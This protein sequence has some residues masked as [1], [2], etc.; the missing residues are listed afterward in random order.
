MPDGFEQ[1]LDVDTYPL[2]DMGNA[3]LFVAAAGYDLHYD[4]ARK[5]GYVYGVD[6]RNGC[7]VWVP[8]PDD[9]LLKQ[10][11]DDYARKLSEMDQALDERMCHC[12]PFHYY[13]RRGPHRFPTQLPQRHSG[14]ADWSVAGTQQDGLHHPGL[15]HRVPP[16]GHD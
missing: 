1:A 3:E 14:S 15:S 5:V 12:R 2:S 6:P 11:I 13:G 10:A 16:G 9:L 7:T 4:A 8:D